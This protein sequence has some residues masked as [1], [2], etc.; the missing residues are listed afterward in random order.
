MAA[1]R[2]GLISIIILVHNY[3]FS[4][5]EI[6]A[7]CAQERGCSTS[8]NFDGNSQKGSVIQFALPP[9]IPSRPPMAAERV[10]LISIIILVHNYIFS[11]PKI[12]AKCAQ[13][14]GRST[15]IKSNDVY[16]YLRIPALP[17]FPPACP[18]LLR[19]PRHL[20]H[21]IPPLKN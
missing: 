5:P 15:S 19:H 8:I 1:E 14:R 4:P 3:I 10:G 17:E 6:P 21:P 9:S 11:A 13:Q 2:V 12:P 20:K 16:M 18:A 7:K